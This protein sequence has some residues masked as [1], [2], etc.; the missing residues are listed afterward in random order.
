V[1]KVRFLKHGEFHGPTF[2]AKDS[3]F[4]EKHDNHRQ[5][6]DYHKD[7]LR[8]QNMAQE[9]AK[10][11]NE[12][13]D[14]AEDHFPSRHHQWFR[15][16]PRIQFVEPFVVEVMEDG[17]RKSY[18]VE[19]MLDG[20]YQKY[21][22]NMGYVE[23]EARHQPQSQQEDNQANDGDLVGQM[24]NLG[25]D[26]LGAIEEGSEEEDS[27]EEEEGSDDDDDEGD[28]DVKIVFDATETAPESGTYRDVKDSYFPQ[29]FSHFTYVK[30]KKN[31]MVVDLQGV[32][33]E[34][35][36]A[37]ACCYELTDPAIHRRGKRFRKWSF[38]RTDRGKKGIK[39][40]LRTHQCTDVCR[41]LG[42]PE[43]DLFRVE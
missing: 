15:Q 43:N 32:L 31:F 2:V 36:A 28:D 41:L 19:K 39:A 11:F 4:V 40:F 27:D 16:R 35:I 22:N 37:D 26:G 7:F 12:A 24:A 42:L 38:G 1:R 34:D 25:L 18:L 10:K 30:S 6:R 20:E 29:A 23:R 33:V 17:H 3:R 9:Y 13:L 21:N 8:T 5:R 14:K